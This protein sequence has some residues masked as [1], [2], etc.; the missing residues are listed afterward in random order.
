M[1]D[2]WR[3]RKTSGPIATL[4][5]EGDKMKL[6]TSRLELVLLGLL[7]FVMLMFCIGKFIT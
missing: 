1:L 5:G 2:F 3:Q 6:E 4:C 7:A